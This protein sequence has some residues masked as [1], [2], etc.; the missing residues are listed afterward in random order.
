MTFVA[1]RSSQ[2]YRQTIHAAPER[3]FPLLCPVREAEWLDGWTCTMVWSKSGVAEEGVVF[4]TSQP[5]EPDTVWVFTRHDPVR[6]EIDFARFTPGSRTCAVRIRVEP[7]GAD[8][9]HVH[10][11]YTYTG[12]SEAGNAWV[13]AYTEEEFRKM[14]LRWKRSMNHYLRTGTKLVEHR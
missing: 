2:S 9:S 1:K 12:L 6:R 7:A 11:T 8:A 3:V 4:T 13:E 14:F 10:I 5:G